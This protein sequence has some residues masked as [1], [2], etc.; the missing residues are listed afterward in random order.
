[1][2]KVLWIVLV[3]LVCNEVQGQQYFQ[4]LADLENKGKFWFFWGYNRSKYTNSNIHFSGTGYDFTLHSVKAKDDPSPWNANTYLNPLKFTIPQFNFRVGYFITDNWSISGG[5]D[6]MK[7]VMVNDEYARIEGYID[8]SVSEEFA[9]VYNKEHILLSKRFLEYEH[10]DGLNYV[11][12]QSDHHLN[13]LTYRDKHRLN[14]INGVGIGIAMPWTDVVFMGKRHRNTLHV[15][16]FGFN[17]TSGLRL[18]VFNHVFAQFSVMG[19]HINLLDVT[20]DN[21]SDDRARQTFWF[22]EHHI[23]MGYQFKL[24]K[25]EKVNVTLPYE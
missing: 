1:M 10:T 22:Y 17:A 21:Q 23:V 9:G 13:L 15:G 4:K 18:E 16:G 11:R 7:Y 5:W 6:H 20:V 19:G 12:F 2:K 8:E 25:R 24:T 3:L 14:W